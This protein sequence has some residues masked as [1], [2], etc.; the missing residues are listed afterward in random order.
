MSRRM[1]F[2]Q[3]IGIL[4]FIMLI[5]FNV[6]EISIKEGFSIVPQVPQMSFANPLHVWNT[7]INSTTVY[8]KAP[9]LMCDTLRY[10]SSFLGDA[11]D[12]FQIRYCIEKPSNQMDNT[13]TLNDIVGNLDMYIQTIEKDT[14]QMSTLR[15]DIERVLFNF[16]QGKKVQGPVYAVISQAPYYPDKEGELLYHQPFNKEQYRFA[17]TLPNHNIPRDGVRLTVHILFPM[18]TKEKQLVTQKTDEER[19]QYIDSL[20]TTEN[21]Q[22]M[23]TNIYDS[24]PALTEEEITDEIKRRIR[25][26]LVD[27]DTY[28]AGEFKTHILSRLAPL[29]ALKSSSNMCKIHCIGDTGLLCGC[30]NQDA[31]Y[32]SRCMGKLNANDRQNTD[33]HDYMILYRINEKSTKLESYFSNMYY[34][35]IAL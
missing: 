10:A 8:D 33:Y 13:K 35:D 28:D 21:I 4:L 29:K 14:T 24:N 16:K 27:Y 19:T 23:A 5:V 22:T 32:L 18:Y 12:V 26:S 15:K 17:P 9:Q 7:E 6:R 31:P 34:E 30:K 20:Y 3:I 25:Q 2:F 11:N 1:L